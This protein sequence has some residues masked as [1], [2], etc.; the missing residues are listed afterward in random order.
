MD[1]NKAIKN[2]G[3]QE[4]KKCNLFFFEGVLFSD[5]HRPALRSI[6]LKL[7]LFLPRFAS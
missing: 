7:L 4:R 5:Q 1:N 2:N 6:L 3:L